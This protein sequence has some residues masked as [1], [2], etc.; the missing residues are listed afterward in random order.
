MTPLHQLGDFLR[1]T[2]E[3]IPLQTVRMLFVGSLVALLIWVLQLPPSA[4]KPPGGATRWDANLKIV[5][6]IALLLQILIYSFF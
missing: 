6:S 5:A 4:T 1:N 2:L 3:G